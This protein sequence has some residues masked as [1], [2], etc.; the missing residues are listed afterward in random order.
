MRRN[1]TLLIA[2]P[3][4]IGWVGGAVWAEDAKPA[5]EDIAAYIGDSPVT[6]KELDAKVL[7]TNMKLAQSLYD[8]RRAAVDDIVIDRALADEAKSKNVSVDQLLKE[9]IA[10]KATPVTDADVNAYYETNKARMG[11]KTLEQ[12]GPQ[13]KNYLASQKEGVARTALLNELKGAAKVRITLDVPRID[14]QLS[15]ND[16]VKGPPT[17]KVTIIEFSDFQ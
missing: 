16:P 9:K 7:K 8:A 17:A 2:V 10:A 13:I 14:F 6:L 5:K 4:L 15:A 12:V 3:T 1:R 11:G